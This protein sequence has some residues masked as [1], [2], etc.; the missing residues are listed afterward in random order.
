MAITWD[1]TLAEREAKGEARGRARAAQDADLR[2]AERRFGVLPSAFQDRIRA[3]Q[4]VDQLYQILDRILE[5]K[6]IEE[7]EL[8]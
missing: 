2:V 1:E 6:S 7:V 8:G 4:D 5:A 3:T